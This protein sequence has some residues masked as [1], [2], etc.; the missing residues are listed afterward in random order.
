M[1]QDGFHYL[2]KA[3]WVCGQTERQCLELV[4]F[5]FPSEVKEAAVA[6]HYL[7]VGVG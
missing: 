2:G 5:A 6:L 7:D 4:D 1:K 3:L